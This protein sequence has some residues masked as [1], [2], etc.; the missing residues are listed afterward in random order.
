METGSNFFFIMGIAFALIILTP[1]LMKYWYVYCFL[2]EVVEGDFKKA[3][4]RIKKE[5]ILEKVLKEEKIKTFVHYKLDELTKLNYSL[6][7]F[8][9]NFA[10]ISLVAS[11]TLSK[12]GGAISLFSLGLNFTF[13]G[14]TIML[15]FYLT[16][17]IWIQT[18]IIELLVKLDELE[19]KLIKELNKK[20]EDED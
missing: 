14:I 15:F 19:I 18:K 2:R 13:F 20:I 7:L 1:F 11:L 9:I 5:K 10:L 3:S 16:I 12:A 17:K 6:A 8:Y 4:K